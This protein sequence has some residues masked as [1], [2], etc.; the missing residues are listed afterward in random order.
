MIRLLLVDDQRLVRAGLRMLCESPADITVVGEA[1]DGQQAVCLAAQEKP[2]VVL[3]D[4]R[5]PGMDGIAATGRILGERP[6][7]RVVVLTTFDD[8]DHLYPALAAGACGFLAKDAAPPELLDAIRRAAA[9][10]SPFSP[11][12]LHRLVR[13]AVTSRRADHSTVPVPQI[14]DR[15]TDILALI[16]AGLSNA[17]IGARLYLGVTT[18]KTHVASLMTKTGCANRVQLAVLAIRQGLVPED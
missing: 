2:D 18:V 8:D 5:M 4:L 14:T 17:D 12:V 3:M 7:T 11:A 13:Q 9:G 1:A 15:E 6:S 16:G 10:E